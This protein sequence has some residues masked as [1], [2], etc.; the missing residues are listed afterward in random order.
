MISLGTLCF[1]ALA[2]AGRVAADGWDDFANNMATDLAPVISLFGEQATKQYLSESIYMIDY[3]IFAMAPI[4]ILTALVSAIRVCGSPSLRAFIGRAKE[5]AGPVEAELLSST[6]R[7]VCELYNSGS[8]TRIFGRPK[9][10]EVVLDSNAPDSD[11]M[12][13]RAA[14]GIFMFRDFVETERGRMEWRSRELKH[15]WGRPPRGN[16]PNLSHN[17]G[18]KRRNYWWFVLAATVGFVLQGGVLALA[19]VAT[20]HLGWE[21]EGSQPPAYACPMAV[22]GTILVCGGVFLCAYL[23][24]ETTEEVIY[25]RTD[26]DKRP[27]S[28]YWL[29]PGQVL[30]DQTFEPFCFVD[31]GGPDSL[32]RYITSWKTIGRM[33]ALLVWSA[34][35]VS[36]VG[37][38][39]QFVG[40]RGIHSAISMAQLGA[41]L[42]MSIARAALRMQRLDTRA[43]MLAGYSK[44]MPA[45][46]LDW[47]AIRMADAE[48][49]ACL[50]RIPIT[51]KPRT[52]YLWTFLG[53]LSSD[54]TAHDA[55]THEDLH[56]VHKLLAYRS[57]LAQHTT[58]DWPEDAQT[59]SRHFKPEMVRV[60]QTAKRLAL[61]I[62]SVANT[63]FQVAPRM[64]DGWQDA[65]TIRWVFDCGVSTNHC[66]D[67][68]DSG[69][70][71]ARK[72]TVKLTRNAHPNGDGG[73]SWKIQNKSDIEA[74]LGLWAF[75][76][77]SDRKSGIITE[78]FYVVDYKR[79]VFLSHDRQE[80]NFRFWTGGR[81][82]L[83]FEE[84]DLQGVVDEDWEP[85]TLWSVPDGEGNDQSLFQ[86]PIKTWE[87]HTLS[88]KQQRFFGWY[89]GEPSS[90]LPSPGKGNPV[91]HHA[92][93][94]DAN[95]DLV[96]M[97]A[98]EVVGVFVK[99][100][101]EATLDIGHVDVDESS[102]ELRIRS[103]LVSELVSGITE[104][105]LTSRDDALLCVLPQIVSKEHQDRRTPLWYAACLGH[106]RMVKSLLN[107][108][109]FDRNAG[110]EEQGRTPLW[111]AAANG[112]DRVVKLLLDAGADAC[113][114]DKDGLAP[115][116]KAAGE[117][118]E[119]VV[120]L[121]L[122][123]TD[124]D[125][126][127]RGPGGKTALWLAA[128][129]G[130]ELVV[131]ALLE[132][133]DITI[134][135]DCG[136][137]PMT[138]AAQNGHELVAK[139]LLHGRDAAAD[140]TTS[141]QRPSLIEDEA[142]VLRNRLGLDPLSDIDPKAAAW[143][144]H[145]RI[146]VLGT[147]LNL[148]SFRE[149]RV[150]LGTP[151]PQGRS[152]TGEP[153]SWTEDE[154]G[155]GTDIASVVFRFAPAAQIFAAKITANLLLDASCMDRMAEAIEYAVNEWDVD[156]VYCGFT[157]PN[158]N[159]RIKASIDVA[160]RKGKIV[161]AAA[162]AVGFDARR[163]YP[164][165]SPHVIAVHPVDGR[166]RDCEISP[167]PIEGEYNFSALGV[168]LMVQGGRGEEEAPFFVADASWATAVA[169]GMAAS[170]LEFARFRLQLEDPEDQK[171]ICSTDGMR[172]MFRLMSTKIDGYDCLAP[173]ELFGGESTDEE[174][175]GIIMM[176]IRKRLG[177]GRHN[178]LT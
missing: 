27:S 88:G 31:S 137:T 62:E 52:E 126:D 58:Y 64:K 44:D 18:I 59:M 26:I 4:G 68:F 77:F 144:D 61:S 152:W 20:Y 102:E 34:L 112:H 166:G 92:W 100:V 36:I 103:R 160:R 139:L 60:R 39:F 87:Q 97:C 91:T 164:A 141:T 45:F 161:M 156:V 38:I 125:P 2:L 78:S 24:G 80:P 8:I 127:L 17:I 57:A 128:F 72:V 43:N 28:I 5:G 120:R 19:V 40:F 108:T 157:M 99:T 69:S 155:W 107:D 23:V 56:C 158:V 25:H 104:T 71:Q 140:T 172:Q 101:L 66:F 3:F 82:P 106:E 124:A 22:V 170:F 145:I 154:F 42:L 149:D 115:L 84:F 130:H 98:Q 113:A 169:A 94:V 151:E 49:E 32:G 119:A 50:G 174:I 37:F 70:Q 63:V 29:Q 30:G 47:L 148:E 16:A 54:M 176:A 123:E 122:D 121:L 75:S 55:R 110:D 118:H 134:A 85:S 90:T 51:V 83:E 135:D 53:M 129:G 21:K 9:I 33:P 10:L 175:C 171:W 12:G 76:V 143:R 15:I 153:S 93:A 46:E 109:E 142:F 7:D 177:G 178:R 111:L 162:G 132:G 73:G 167:V 79:L 89:T 11:F 168:A 65:T 114:A 86:S 96:S 173:W 138:V 14:S 133:A 116:C 41:A 147:G 74:I 13:P 136:V 6:S 117:G 105:E 48:L 159:R 95:S 1:T 81:L 146:A 163:S 131:K 165:S 150:W 67:S 35:C